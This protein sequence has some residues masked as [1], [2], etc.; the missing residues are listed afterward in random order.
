MTQHALVDSVQSNEALEQ[1]AARFA[2][3]TLSLDGLA[4]LHRMDNESVLAVL[5]DP[6]LQKRIEHAVVTREQS[7]DTSREI[8]RRALASCLRRI[9]QIVEDPE[10]STTTL[11]RATELLD[12]IAP[13]TPKVADAPSRGVGSVTIVFTNPPREEK[14]GGVIDV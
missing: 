6:E 13:L 14:Y 2:A 4:A 12:R 10:T 11:L 9:S 8:A 5:E 7:G 3:G 1:D